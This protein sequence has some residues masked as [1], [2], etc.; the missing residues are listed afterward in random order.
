M[1]SR[2]YWFW[3]IEKANLIH[4]KHTHLSYCNP[5]QYK[6]RIGIY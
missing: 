6:H 2:Y 1:D 4:N 3:Q 5:M